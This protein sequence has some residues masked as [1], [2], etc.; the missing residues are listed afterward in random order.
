MANLMMEKRST[1]RCHWGLRNSMKMMQ[2]YCLKIAF[3]IEASGDCFLQ[4]ASCC[5]K[6]D[7]TQT[8]LS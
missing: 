8:K 4:E 6:Q 5:S 3:I 7:W 1:S 2:F